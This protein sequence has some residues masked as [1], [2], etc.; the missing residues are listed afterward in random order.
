MRQELIDYFKSLKL[1]NFKVSDELPFSNS[2]RT[3][4]LKN[5]KSIYTDLEQKTQ[6]Q[7]IPVLGNHGVFQEVHIVSVFFTTDAKNL[8]SDYQTVVDS[9]KNG[10][11]ITTT[12][13]YFKREVDS[14]T[15]FEGDLMVTQLD[16]RFTKLT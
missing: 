13:I 7:I 8:P 4:Y 1:R 14:T 2:D 16:F 9:L 6:E 10:K 5:P 15:S 3:V 11:G 12:E